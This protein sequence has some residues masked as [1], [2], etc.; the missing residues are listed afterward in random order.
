MNHFW[1]CTTAKVLQRQLKSIKGDYY[2]ERLYRSTTNTNPTAVS[3]VRLDYSLQTARWKQPSAS[4]PVI[5]IISAAA[6][7]NL[8]EQ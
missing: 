2:K 5:L 6:E 8:Y 3:M 1:D 7:M 4:I